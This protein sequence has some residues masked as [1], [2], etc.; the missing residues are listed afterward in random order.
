MKITT[1]YNSM[2]L[3]FDENIKELDERKN[4]NSEFIGYPILPTE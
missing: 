3:L 4:Y 2:H 1:K